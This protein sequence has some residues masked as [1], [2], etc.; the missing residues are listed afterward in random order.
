MAGLGLTGYLV[1]LS[2]LS[3]NLLVWSVWTV[4]GERETEPRSCQGQ[5]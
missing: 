4:K 5:R 3:R 1:L 2:F